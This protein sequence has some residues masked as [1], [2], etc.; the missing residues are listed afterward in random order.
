MLQV[1]P[2]LEPSSTSQLGAVRRELVSS[3]AEQARALIWP[4]KGAHRRS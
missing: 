2:S 1:A 4:V 3:S